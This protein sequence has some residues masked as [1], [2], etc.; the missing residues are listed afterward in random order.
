MQ[1]EKY[2]EICFQ[3]LLHDWMPPELVLR[4]GQTQQQAVDAMVEQLPWLPVADVRAHVAAIFARRE[5]F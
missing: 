5:R 1:D 3:V 4:A 2:G